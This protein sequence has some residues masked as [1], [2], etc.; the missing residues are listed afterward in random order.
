MKL[1]LKAKFLIPILLLFGIG[2]A[3]V[4]ITSSIIAEDAMEKAITAQMVQ[5]ADSTHKHLDSWIEFNLEDLHH[6]SHN[7]FLRISLLDSFMGKASRQTTNLFLEEEKNPN[8]Q[9]VSL[10]DIN[11]KIVS[12]SDSETIGKKTVSDRDFFKS[13]IKGAQGFFDN[14]EFG[15][16]FYISAIPVYKNYDETKIAGVLYA[17]IS[18]E[19]FNR[20]YID[21]IKIGKRGRVHLTNRD[22]TVIAHPDKSKI[23]KPCPLKTEYL[24]LITNDTLPLFSDTPVIDNSES[25][26]VFKNHSLSGWKIM[27]SAEK[28][29]IMEPVER[30]VR[31]DFLVAL[32]FIIFVTILVL[33]IIGSLIKPLTLLTEAS[34]NA[35]EG[36]FDIDFE[37]KTG[38]EIQVLADGFA[39]MIDKRKDAEFSLKN[40]RAMLAVRVEERTA[41]LRAA[42]DELQ[43]TSRYKDEF[44][45]NM[46]HELRTPLTT[47]L[48]MVEALLEKVY[49]PLTNKQLSPLQLVNK[50]SEH[51]LSLINSILDLAKINAGKEDLDIEQVPL[52][53]LC[54]SSIELVNGISETKNQKIIFKNETNLS[55][56]QADKLRIKQVL[57]NLLTNAVKF[58]PEGGKIGI[59]VICPSD[60]DIV[61]FTVWDTGIG[62]PNENIERVFQP[63]AQVDGSF[64]REYEGTGLG[65]ALVS[66]LVELH[67]GSVAIKSKEGHF[68]RVSVELPLDTSEKNS[69]NRLDEIEAIAGQPDLGTSRKSATILLVDDNEAIIE[70]IGQYL[71]A[72]SYDVVVA[73]N[74]SKALE[75]NNQKKP[76]IIIMDIQMP[77]ID[78]LEVIR[79]IRQEEG[80]IKRVPIIALTALA[81][82]GD[83]EKCL[84][85][86]ADE[87]MSKPV[88]LKGLV[89]RINHWLQNN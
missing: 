42:N 8:W 89:A 34:K 56:I 4:A 37:I 87:Y 11:G 75:L 66:K 35:A 88:K 46:S 32:L 3:A 80:G 61:T 65:L 52:E 19:D 29:D 84:D 47:I 60:R 23:L 73:N 10:A 72:F 76:D 22:F 41:E 86:G 36:E 53:A 40:E 85:A 81:M 62:I 14:V 45:A 68:T 51:L 24:Q 58:T 6:I 25:V 55:H 54:R 9:S 64:T 33:V 59:D 13:A 43:Q 27:V 15:K 69:I 12:S 70:T 78:G 16:S 44:L 50:S 28:S 18:L 48:G 67:K 71:E 31:I 49:G 39:K 7:E 74:G 57:V 77:G 38:D 26:I 17:T 21:P 63:F 5:I 82:K 30:L 20:K 1:N 83:R 2:I 79:L